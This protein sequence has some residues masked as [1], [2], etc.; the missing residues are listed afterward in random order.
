MVHNDRF[1]MV[2]HETFFN[3]SVINYPTMLVDIQELCFQ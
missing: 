3:E 1:N 2:H